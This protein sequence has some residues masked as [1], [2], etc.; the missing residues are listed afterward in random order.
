MP[1]QTQ[2]IKTPMLVLGAA[3]DFFID[4]D[5]MQ[6]TAHAYGTKPEIFANMAHDMML[7]AGWKLVANR[8]VEWLTVQ[9]L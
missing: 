3:N 2:K 4:A 9:K 5:E 1:V 7:E 6:E 8:M